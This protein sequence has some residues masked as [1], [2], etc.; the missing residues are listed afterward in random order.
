VAV[1]SAAY[2]TIGRF[3]SNDVYMPLTPMF[4][5]HA[6]GFPYVATLL[7]VKQVYPGQYEAERLLKLITREKVTF[8]HCVPKIS[9]NIYKNVPGRVKYRNT[10]FRIVTNWWM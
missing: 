4:H 9:S 2:H 7:G 8:S 6:W 3:R 5:V 10:R 1:A